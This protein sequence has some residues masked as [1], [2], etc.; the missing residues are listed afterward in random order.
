MNK[1]ITCDLHHMCCSP[2]IQVRE[3]LLDNTVQHLVIR[4]A[5]EP[6]YMGL[7]VKS[8]DELISQLQTARD[9]L[10]T[11]TDWTPGISTCGVVDCDV[12]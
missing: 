11:V 9:A 12:C 6:W 8:I 1:W 10:S 5:G 3:S 7:S 2:E 4:V